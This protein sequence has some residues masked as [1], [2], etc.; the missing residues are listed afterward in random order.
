MYAFVDGAVDKNR[1]RDQGGAG[2]GGAG[3]VLVATDRDSIT[4][5]RVIGVPFWPHSIFI[6]NNTMEIMAVMV[7]CNAMSEEIALGKT[8]HIWSDS[9]YAK[10]SLSFGSNWT[11]KK[12][13][14][15][16]E[17][18]RRTTAKS[19]VQIYHCKGHAGYS[20]NELANTAAQKAVELKKGFDAT[21]KASIGRVCLFCN[22]FPCQDQ[23]KK[24]GVRDSFLSAKDGYAGILECDEFAKPPRKILEEVM[25]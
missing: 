3:V 2:F 14:G 20:W 11:A 23:D 19:N 10:G 6:T 1:R 13:I 18:A 8:V 24:F 17:Y 5:Y 22:K 7:A 25:S 16:I 21:F 4:S 12:N 15:L 9:T